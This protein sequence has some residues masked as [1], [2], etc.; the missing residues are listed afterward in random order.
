MWFFERICGWI[1]MS[2]SH[3]SQNTIAL[4]VIPA[5]AG[6]QIRD[7]W[8]GFV[9]SWFCGCFPVLASLGPRV[10]GDDGLG[11]AGRLRQQVVGET[12][13]ENQTDS[14]AG[15]EGRLSEKT[16]GK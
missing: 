16:G 14:A 4:F 7:G 11:G 13:F 6:T 3:S 12:R 10:R 15:P 2:F 8:T 5:Q 1:L 9:C